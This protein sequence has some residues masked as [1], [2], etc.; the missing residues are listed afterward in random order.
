MIP[1]VTL[2]AFT[3]IGIEG[4]ASEIEFPFGIDSS[5]LPLDLMTAE[6]R[7]EVEHMISRLSTHS[8]DWM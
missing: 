4:I 5:D 1:F 8:D 7:N 2:C 3:L 6:L